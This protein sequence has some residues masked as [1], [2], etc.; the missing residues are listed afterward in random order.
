MGISKRLK[1]GNGAHMFDHVSVTNMYVGMSKHQYNKNTRG[2]ASVSGYKNMHDFSID[3]ITHKRRTR[4][5]Y[6]FE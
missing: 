3:T 1:V 5:R 4:Q 6:L 2:D